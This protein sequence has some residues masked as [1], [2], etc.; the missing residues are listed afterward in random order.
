MYKQTVAE[1]LESPLIC[2]QDEVH[3]GSSGVKYHMTQNKQNSWGESGSKYLIVRD[4]HQPT[5]LVFC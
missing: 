1:S 2:A 5:E 4:F 3:H